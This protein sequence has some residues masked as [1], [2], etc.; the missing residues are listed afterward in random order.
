MAEGFLSPYLTTVKWLDLSIWMPNTSKKTA[1]SRLWN[2]EATKLIDAYSTALT[3]NS[4]NL[5]TYSRATNNQFRIFNGL[6]NELCFA[7]RRKL[8]WLKTKNKVDK[9]SLKSYFTYYENF[10]KIVKIT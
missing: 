10:V 3:L 9:I 4:S 1:H 6:E 2:L 8:N 7:N 5:A